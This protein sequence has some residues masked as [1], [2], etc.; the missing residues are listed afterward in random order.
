M[1]TRPEGN[2][3]KAPPLAPFLGLE[4][5]FPAQTASAGAATCLGAPQPWGH[6]AGATFGHLHRVPE[7]GPRKP[8]AGRGVAGRGCEQPPEGR[9]PPATP[10]PSPPVP[11]GAAAASSILCPRSRLRGDGGGGHTHTRRRPKGSAPRGA[12]RP[13]RAPSG[14]REGEPLTAGLPQGGLAS[15]A[16]P[17]RRG[18]RGSL[19]SRLRGAGP[20]GARLL[21]GTSRPSL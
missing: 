12:E 10:T 4:V 9:Q 15:G 7:G 8:P 11:S 20:A 3:S 21:A 6:R 19:R 2:P 5:H 16:A 13:G 1:G 18:G 14:Q 17:W